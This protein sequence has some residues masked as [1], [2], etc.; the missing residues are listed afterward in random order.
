MRNKR[1]DYSKEQV[2]SIKYENS[3][4]SKIVVRPLLEQDAKV[5]Y[6]ATCEQIKYSSIHKQQ[7][8]YLN[9]TNT[10]TVVQIHIIKNFTNGITTKSSKY[11][12]AAIWRLSKSAKP[13]LS[14]PKATKP[15]GGKA[16]TFP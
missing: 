6:A 9:Y 12:A 2:N 7:I 14:V 16:V 1:T 10:E 13:K 11:Y 3:C 4:H 5:N 8:R 15:L